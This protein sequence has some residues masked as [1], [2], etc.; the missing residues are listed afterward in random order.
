MSFAGAPRPVLPLLDWRRRVLP[1]VSTIDSR[2]LSVVVSARCG[3]AGAPDAGDGARKGE[4]TQ[5]EA[6]TLQVEEVGGR[7]AG[8]GDQSKVFSLSPEQ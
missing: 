7:E 1:F 3:D 8:S 2:L 5:G 4:V 6:G